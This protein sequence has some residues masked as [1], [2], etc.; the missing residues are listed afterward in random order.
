VCVPNVRTVQTQELLVVECL[1][2]SLYAF[3]RAPST[4]S[5]VELTVSGLG[6]VLRVSKCYIVV[7]DCDE[8]QAMCL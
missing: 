3:F 1:G 5:D 8:V 6:P 7:G 4:A 2:L